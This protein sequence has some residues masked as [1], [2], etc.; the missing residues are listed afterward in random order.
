MGESSETFGSGG[1]ARKDS[2]FG[3]F[4]GSAYT[5][6]IPSFGPDVSER[7][8]KIAKLN[9]GKLTPTT[10]AFTD[11]QCNEFVGEVIK[12][13]PN[14]ESIVKAD[15]ADIHWSIL[16]LLVIHGGEERA[17]TSNV[18]TLLAGERGY[19]I[20]LR[21]LVEA[22]AAVNGGTVRRFTRAQSASVRELFA[23]EC[24]LNEFRRVMGTNADI[25][26]KRSDLLHKDYEHK[27]GAGQY[28]VLRVKR[29]ARDVYKA[30][31]ESLD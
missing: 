6:G 29:L 19:D 21:T 31:E 17:L 30:D 3:K 4:S 26:K 11:D 12:R 7:F 1:V 25:Y 14:G 15:H 28:D 18:V 24:V 13:V 20:P 10:G 27:F 9:A 5:R 22:A 23:D 16:M 2:L 8:K